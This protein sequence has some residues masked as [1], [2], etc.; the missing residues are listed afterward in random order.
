[1]QRKIDPDPAAIILVAVGIGGLV[2]STVNLAATLVRLGW[3]RQ[4]VRAT[5]RLRL[6]L[7]KLGAEVGSLQHWVNEIAEL[8][9]V[10]G[11]NQPCLPGQDG[12]WLTPN[13]VDVYNE[14]Q[15]AVARSFLLISE[16]TRNITDCVLDLGTQQEEVP[17]PAIPAFQERGN[18]FYRGE[19]PMSHAYREFNLY[20]DDIKKWIAQ[21]EAMIQ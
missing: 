5:R 12:A 9:D 1:M 16:Y 6:Y 15:L 19:K 20:L 17:P 2:V 18:S 10:P 7:Q 4:Q 21:V 13:Q 11:S 14:K 8:F 3:D